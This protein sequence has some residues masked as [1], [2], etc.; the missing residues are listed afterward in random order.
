MVDKKGI[1]W[2]AGILHQGIGLV[3]KVGIHPLVFDIWNNP[4]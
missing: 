4:K 3:G 1:S 2:A